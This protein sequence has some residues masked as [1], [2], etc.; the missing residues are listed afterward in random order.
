MADLYGRDKE[1]KDQL[2]PDQLKQW[3]HDFI[4]AVVWGMAVGAG[5]VV[6]VFVLFMSV[7]AGK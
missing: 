3:R 1:L 6:A 7:A 4:W 5:L 2:T